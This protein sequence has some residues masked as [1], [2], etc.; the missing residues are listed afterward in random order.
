M[1]NNADPFG[2][3]LLAKIHIKGHI[4]FQGEHPIASG[5][6]E[7]DYIAYEAYEVTP[8]HEGFAD[9]VNKFPTEGLN[10]WELNIAQ[11]LLAKTFPLFV[12]V[13]GKVFA[14]Y[15]LIYIYNYMLFNGSRNVDG[16]GFDK[17]ENRPTN[18]QIPLIRK[19]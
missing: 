15:D 5:A 11:N 4:V 16:R 12:L 18:L 10:K 1:N 19:S 7:V 2:K 17:P 3:I 14:E 13:T 8:L 9:A 6:Y